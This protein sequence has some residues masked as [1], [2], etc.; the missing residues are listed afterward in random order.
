[1]DLSTSNNP[2]GFFIDVITYSYLYSVSYGPIEKS[3]HS[4]ESNMP[5]FYLSLGGLG[6]ITKLEGYGYLYAV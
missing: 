3:C 4:S 5:L 2:E 6:K 1:M